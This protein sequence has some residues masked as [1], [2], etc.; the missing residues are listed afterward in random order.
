M[1]YCTFVKEIQ[2]WDAINL[3]QY[4]FWTSEIGEFLN[5]IR[6][7]QQKIQNI[8]FIT[9]MEGEI[10]SIILKLSFEV[11]NGI[12]RVFSWVMAGF[13][14]NAHVR[15]ARSLLRSYYDWMENDALIC[16]LHSCVLISL[17]PGV[18]ETAIMLGAYR[19]VPWTKSNIDQITKVK[20][21][22]IQ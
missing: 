18:H 9:T 20:S 15:L 22:S 14:M 8:A 1:H 10:L 11:G 6:L 4:W 21:N 13:R 17:H 2:A 19:R 16:N 5:V 7:W 3:R 12:L